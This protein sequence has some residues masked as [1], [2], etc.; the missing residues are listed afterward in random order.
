MSNS[1]GNCNRDIRKFCRENGIKPSAANVDLI[2]KEVRRTSQDNERHDAREKAR[3]GAR[4]VDN[5]GRDV[6]A[7]RKDYVLRQ[8]AKRNEPRR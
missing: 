8:L 5:A 3:G 7:A 2:A 1:L 4:A 6:E